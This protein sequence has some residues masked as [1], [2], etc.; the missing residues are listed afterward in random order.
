MKAIYLKQHAGAKQAF[1][2]REAPMPTCADDE[3]LIEVSCFGLN[4]AEIMAR[5]GLY[6]DAPALPFIPGYEV[7]GKICAVGNEMNQHLVGKNVIAFTRFGGYAQ[8]TLTKANACLETGTHDAAE[9]CCL[10]VQYATAW[11]MA[12]YTTQLRKGDKVLIHAGAG[13]VGTALIQ[14][15]KLAGATIY[16]IGGNHEKEEYMRNQGADFVLNHQTANYAEVWKDELFD[17]I[18]NPVGGSTFKQDKKLLRAG[19]RLIMYGASERKAGFKFWNGIKFL[20]KMGF[21]LPILLVRDSVSLMGVN[22]IRIAD[23]KPEV[24]AT[25][26]HEVYKL[27]EAG[28]IKPHVGARFAFTEIAE[29]H[30]FLESRKSIGKVVVMV[31][32]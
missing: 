10:A 20:R 4:Y 21:L 14:L 27:Y 12:D 8:Y 19:G 15:C 1:E 25:C 2:Y 26:L 28:K 18:F 32:K 24:L 22:M 3:V 7:A 16:A 31:Q 11:Y 30:T 5:N 17:V 23:Q 6:G 9:L 13:G 29:A